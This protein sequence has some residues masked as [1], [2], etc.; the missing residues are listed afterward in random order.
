MRGAALGCHLIPAHHND[1]MEVGYRELV[2]GSGSVGWKGS[3]GNRGL[4][5]LSH[6]PSLLMSLLAQRVRFR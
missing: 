6:G 2:G 3:W 5:S 4:V 1:W